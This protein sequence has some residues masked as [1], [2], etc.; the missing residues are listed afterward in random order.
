LRRLLYWAIL[1]ILVIAA[2]IRVFHHDFATT[3][4]IALAIVLFLV[5]Y[6]RLD[7]P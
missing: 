2:A 4:V 5:L 1:T 6:D 7:R 3:T